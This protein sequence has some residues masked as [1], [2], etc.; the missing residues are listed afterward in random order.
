MASTDETVSDPRS[1]RVGNGDICAVLDYLMPGKSLHSARRAAQASQDGKEAM[2]NMTGIPSSQM[3][4]SGHSLM[5]SQGVH[6]ALRR[7]S[8]KLTAS[9]SINGSARVREHLVLLARPAPSRNQ[10]HVGPQTGFRA[11]KWLLLKQY[12]PPTLPWA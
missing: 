5:A 7:P 8:T 10:C 6:E 12:V 11:T 1:W 4:V 3:L 9:T 2:L